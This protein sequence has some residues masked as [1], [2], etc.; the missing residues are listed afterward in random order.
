MMSHGQVLGTV[1][2]VAVFAI[3][4]YIE[5]RRNKWFS[6]YMRRTHGEDWDK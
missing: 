4:C 5:K 2:M 6:D 1:L 3:G